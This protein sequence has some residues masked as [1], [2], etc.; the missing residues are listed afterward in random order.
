MASIQSYEI[1]SNLTRKVQRACES[2]SINF[3][4]GAGC[5]VP[6]FKTLGNIE[7]LRTILEC[8]KDIRDLHR[9]RIRLSLDAQFFKTAIFPNTLY[10]AKDVNNRQIDQVRKYYAEFCEASLKL[11]SERAATTLPRQ[12][13]YF[14]SNYDLCLDAALDRLATP[15]NRGYIG[16]YNT[17]VSL[18]DFGNRYYTNTLTLGYRAELTSANLVKIHGCAS[19]STRPA[20]LHFTDPSHELKTMHDMIESAI[21]ERKLSVFDTTDTAKTVYASLKAA[22]NIRRHHRDKDLDELERRLSSLALVMPNKT[23]FESTVLNET[24]YAQLRRLTNQLEVRNSVLFVAGFSFADEHIRKLI[25]RAAA[26]NP[27]LNIYIF[28]YNEDAECAIRHIIENDGGAPN[29]NITTILGEIN[30]E[31]DEPTRSN[32][33]LPEISKFLQNIS[34]RTRD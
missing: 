18:S 3:L 13:T 30:R 16:Q 33:G 29:K 9:Q 6:A 23:K 14:T 15:T 25:I 31:D 20:P 5:S 10:L 28:C 7:E 8:D 19:W 2:A 4:L 34:S 21:K 27:T 1:H 26:T 22:T 24:Y 11:V 32:L 17:N 12:V